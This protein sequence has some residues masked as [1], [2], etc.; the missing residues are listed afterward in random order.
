[1]YLEQLTNDQRAWVEKFQVMLEVA[2][3]PKSVNYLRF[4]VD[5]RGGF[6]LLYKAPNNI[7][8]FEID[9][10]DRYSVEQFEFQVERLIERMHVALGLAYNDLLNENKGLKKEL[11]E[12][13]QLANDGMVEG[14][15]G[16][17]TPAGQKFLKIVDMA[18]RVNL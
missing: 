4:W 16:V 18:R 1:M 10:T 14:G 3:L 15:I 11:A 13:G 8:G 6:H 2:K 5:E 17:Y 7:G 12:A 9:V